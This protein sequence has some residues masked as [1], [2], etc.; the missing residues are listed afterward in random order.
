MLYRK[1]YLHHNKDGHGPKDHGPGPT[2]DGHGSVLPGSFS[3]V[4]THWH[5]GRKPEWR[6]LGSLELVEVVA[7]RGELLLLALALADGEGELVELAARGHRVPALHRLPVA[8]GALGEGLAG[9]R[10]A[11][12]AGETEGFRDRQVRAHL[13]QV[14]ARTLLLMEDDPAALVHAVVDPALGLRG[15]SDVDEEDRLLE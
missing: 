12:G 3:P 4:L 8:E 2:K 1:D 15:C 11:K 7:E 13:H 6:E 5:A 14:R 10:L 9:R